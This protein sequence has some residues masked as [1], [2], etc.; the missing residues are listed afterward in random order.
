[1]LATHYLGI[2]LGN[3]GRGA[4]GREGWEGGYRVHRGYLTLLNVCHEEWKSRWKQMQGTAGNR[5]LK[6]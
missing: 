4:L 3:Q 2:W 6:K 5:K 1:M